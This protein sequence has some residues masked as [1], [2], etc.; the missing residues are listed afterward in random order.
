MSLELS[1][2]RAEK[3]RIILPLKVNAIVKVDPPKPKQKIAA[4]PR[5]RTPSPKL[6]PVRRGSDAFRF[7]MFS[8]K[9]LEMLNQ[10]G[11]SADRTPKTGEQ[12]VVAISA[13]KQPNVTKV[14]HMLVRV[15]N[16]GKVALSGVFVFFH[17]EGSSVLRGVSFGG[18]Q[19]ILKA[20]P[21]SFVPFRRSNGTVRPGLIG[22]DET[23]NRVVYNAEPL[24]PGQW[25]QFQVVVEFGESRRFKAKVSVICAGGARG[26]DSKVFVAGS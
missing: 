19:P 20:S 5:R 7:F 26:G 9:K 18:I 21:P 22:V 11:E 17:I 6:F 2:T 14:R 13:A 23:N 3:Q 1:T 15:S 16:T 24:V 8:P 25:V 4:K 10:L 12:V